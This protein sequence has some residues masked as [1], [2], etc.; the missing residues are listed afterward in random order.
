MTEQSWFWDI[1]RSVLASLD[2]AIYGLVQTLYQ[3]FA[4]IS[5]LTIFDNDIFTSFREKIYLLLGIVMLF[6]VAFSLITLLAN[7]DDLMDSKKGITGIV[8]RIIISLVLITFVPTLFATAFRVQRIIIDDNIIGQFFLG[9]LEDVKDDVMVNS[10]NMVAFHVLNAFYYPEPAL[11]K[12]RGIDCVESKD[13]EMFNIDDDRGGGTTRK[14]S[15]LPPHRIKCKGEK[16]YAKEGFYYLTHYSYDV[17]QYLDQYVNEQA[18]ADG[19]GSGTDYYAM[20]YT[21]GI[22]TIAGVVVAWMFLGYCVDAA[23]RAIKL[24]V[25][26]LIAPIPIFSYIDPKKGEGIFQN[27]LKTTTST[28][29]SLFGRLILIYFVLY[30]CHQLTTGGGIQVITATGATEKLTDGSMMARFAQAFIVIGLILFAKD[31]PALFSEMFGIK[32]EKSYGSTLAKMGMTGTALGVGLGGAKLFGGLARRHVEKKDLRQK[33]A[34]L[35]NG[36]SETEL[37]AEEQAELAKIR[38]KKSLGYGAK[39][40]TRGVGMGALYG[41]LAGKGM[42]PTLSAYR[43]ARSTANQK[44]KVREDGLGFFREQKEKYLQNIG[45]GGTYGEFGG[46][47]NKLKELENKR[48]TYQGIEHRLREQYTDQLAK[49][50]T[51]YDIND[52]IMDLYRDEALK[53]DVNERALSD[54]IEKVKKSYVDDL[55][56][57]D[58]SA[59]EIAKLTES[60]NKQFDDMHKLLLQSKKYDELGEKIE[61]EIG[62]TKKRIDSISSGGKK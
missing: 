53:K 56:T 12:V 25:L 23:V 2:S 24:G 49:L 39:Q 8:Q 6:K 58:H 55:S 27:W 61:K 37:S 33:E 5:Q 50:T 29:L 10:G 22:S 47:K 31:A 36:R 19:S 62:D 9:D 16:L 60:F 35:L 14:V 7:P 17:S 45:A 38:D 1:I 40:I 44:Q 57:T 34:D 41:A 13:V 51:N 20:H 48:R 15:V 42:K 52:N 54:A 46:E 18:G 28:Y 11:E 30:V 43:Q 32:M 21:W 26:Q 59:D 4:Y 3:L